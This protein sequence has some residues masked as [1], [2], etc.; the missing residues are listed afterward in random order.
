M[1]R[2]RMFGY[3]YSLDVWGGTK[4]F[5]EDITSDLLEYFAHV[6]VWAKPDLGR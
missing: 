2:L 6:E 3:R 4:L 5:Q 1:L